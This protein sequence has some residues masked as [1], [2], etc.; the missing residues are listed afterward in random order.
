[1][2]ILRQSQEFNQVR[3]LNETI[4]CDDKKKKNGKHINSYFLHSHLEPSLHFKKKKKKIEQGEKW[5]YFSKF[6]F[7]IHVYYINKLALSPYDLEGAHNKVASECENTADL[8]YL[9]LAS[10][11]F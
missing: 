1:M 4:Q 9:S 7:W 2:L 5:D 10:I 3:R 6:N 8:G 11:T